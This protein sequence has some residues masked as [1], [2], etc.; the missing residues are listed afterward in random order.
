MNKKPGNNH[1]CWSP[2]C[3]RGHFPGF[4]A[5]GGLVIVANNMSQ[6]CSELPGVSRH[7]RYMVLLIC[8]WDE[9]LWLRTP[10]SLA[11]FGPSHSQVMGKKESRYPPCLAA[12]CKSPELHRRGWELLRDSASSC[13]MSLTAGVKPWMTSCERPHTWDIKVLFSCW[14]KLG[15]AAHELQSAWATFKEHLLT[16]GNNNAFWKAWEL[17]F[18]SLF[19]FLVFFSE[20]WNSFV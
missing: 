17:F 8:S 5:P 2:L 13:P 6:T 3:L 11:C 4:G 18:F 9:P 12:V 16:A 1:V 15:T 19:S 14:S 20:F 7:G 10:R